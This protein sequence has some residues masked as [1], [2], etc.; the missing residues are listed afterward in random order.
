LVETLKTYFSTGESKAKTAEK[1]YIH[2]N[3]LKYRLHKIEEILGLK[4]SDPDVSF[5]L[6]LAVRLLLFV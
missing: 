4:L 6:K 1:L 3:T 2:L 5:R